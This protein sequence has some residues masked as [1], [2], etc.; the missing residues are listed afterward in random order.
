[1]DQRMVSPVSLLRGMGVPRQCTELPCFQC[2]N[3]II[4]LD[5][6]KLNGPVSPPPPP[7]PHISHVAPARCS[8]YI[9][10]CPP[11]RNLMKVR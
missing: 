6:N 4:G 3:Y 8:L 1:M 9:I 11:G 2:G 7:F 5:L 10:I